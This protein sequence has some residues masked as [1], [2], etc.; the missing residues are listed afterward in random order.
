MSAPRRPRARAAIALLL[1]VLMSVAGCQHE[2]DDGGDGRGSQP[3]PRPVTDDEA[4]RLATMRFRNFDAGS[5]QVS[6]S[7]QD[8]GHE[9]QVEGWFDYAGGGGYAAVSTDGVPSDVVVWDH[10]HV[11]VT[12]APATASGP[13]VEWLGPP[14][15]SFDGWSIAPLDPSASPIE[16]LFAMLARLGNDRPE[17]PLLLREGGALWL[18]EDDV[19]GEA[20][21]V[22]AGPTSGSDRGTDDQQPSPED[23]GGPPDPA[24]AGVRYWIDEAGMAHRVE[25]R[26]ADGWAR[27]DLTD[28]DGPDIGPPPHPAGAS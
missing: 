22:F 6:A 9:V 24:A 1:L 5:R 28:N 4:E 3:E 17:N 18:R 7:Y 14:P 15:Q 26:L 16:A 10:E 12:A 11:A 27:V 23:D 8:G 2:E 20:V 25:I 21:T 13:P 19:G